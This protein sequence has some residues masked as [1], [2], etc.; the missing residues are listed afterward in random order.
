MKLLNSRRPAAFHVLTASVLILNGCAAAVVGGSA[1]TVHDRRTVGT[2]FDDQTIEYQVIDKLYS[3]EELGKESHLK[4]EVYQSVVLLT[5]ET[6]TEQRRARAGEL[7][8]AVPN[9]ERV[10][11]EI[12]LESRASLLGKANNAWLTT[13]V[14]T[15]LIKHNPLPGF[16]A[17]RIKVVSS[18]DTV[19]LM[20]LVT[21]D[22]GDAVAEVA[23]NVSGVGRVVKVFNYMD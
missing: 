4:V 18:N 22:E 12:Q 1:V 7:A 15:A 16:D 8:A 17:T 20:G 11:N 2:V 23:R 10:V 5:G 21:R 6:D 9:V 14:N 13:K 3:S 19:F